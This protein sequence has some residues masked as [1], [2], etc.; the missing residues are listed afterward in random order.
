MYRSS[1]HRKAAFPSSEVRA[2]L[3]QPAIILTLPLQLI[4][5]MDILFV[6]HGT[7]VANVRKR[8]VLFDT[9]IL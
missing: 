2:C 1:S 7:S 8:Q 4:P 3:D 9:G 5:P 6:A